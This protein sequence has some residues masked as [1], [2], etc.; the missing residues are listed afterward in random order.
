[1]AIP[2]VFVSSTCFDLGEVRDQLKKFIISFGFD[3]VL[4]EYG[5]VFYHP[6]LHTHD[7]CIQEVAHCQLFILII[8]GRFGGEYQADKSKSIT[9][10]EY[11][12]AK[13]SNIPIFTY[14]K[15]DVLSSQFLYKQNRDQEFAGKIN[16]PAID[17][18]EHALDIFN[19][20]GD[21]QRADTN[22]GVE[23]FEN[24]QDIE[25]HL[26]K[27]WAGM[28]FDFL[29]T[30]EVKSQID[31]TNHLL[32]GLQQSHEQVEELIKSLYIS[33]KPQEAE[34]NIELL[35]YRN[36]IEEWFRKLFGLSET[37]ISNIDL[38]KIHMEA[39][40]NISPKKLSIREYWLETKLYKN[41]VDE[42]TNKEVLRP[43]FFKDNFI[44]YRVSHFLPITIETFDKDI[45]NTNKEFRYEIMKKI[46]LKHPG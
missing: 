10:A 32:S 34:K 28:F 1:M 46:L 27:Q 2:K 30:R 21:V 7:A 31:A 38:D 13:E 40:S 36:E 22:N 44:P 16:Y 15:K 45:K 19:F 43:L 12:A 9:N 42:K 39:I 33:V 5:D 24:F 20:M 6:D 25:N 29:K 3:A 26:K 8:G 14:I 35:E 41:D 11:I 18:Q 4:S 23:S 17:K 37:D